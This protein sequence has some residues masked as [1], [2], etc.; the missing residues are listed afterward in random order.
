VTTGS[1]ASRL[2]ALLLLVAVLVVAYALIGW[3]LQSAYQEA[4]ADIGDRRH[5][6]ARLNAA[7]A[8]DDVLAARLES[9]GDTTR[10]AIVLAETDSSA[11]ALLQS[12][13][14]TLLE[15]A[16]AELTSIEALPSDDGGDYRAVRVRAQFTTGHD[17]L[18]QVLF[19]LESGRP[20]VFLDNLTVSARS[21]RAF[22]VDRP[23]D[24]QVDLT[25]YRGAGSQP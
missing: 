6:L 15:T 2:T 1:V 24:I 9:G 22:G 13:L 21:V 4:L 18:R 8:R 12:H 7:Q 23:L 10:S 16:D 11:A 25:A 19:A 14:Q 20:T 17:G 5:A 3:P